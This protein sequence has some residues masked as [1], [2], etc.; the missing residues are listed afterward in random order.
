M[1]DDTKEF[2]EM[3]QKL[4]DE[5]SSEAMEDAKGKTKAELIK[6]IGI[7]AG[8]IVSL[9]AVDAMQEKIIE[10]Q[11]EEQPNPYLWAIGGALAVFAGFIFVG[12]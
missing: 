9:Q 1:T 8:L 3:L 11:E 7:M 10:A 6:D 12:L 4:T 5:A 2:Q